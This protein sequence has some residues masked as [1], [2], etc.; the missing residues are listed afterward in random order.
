MIKYLEIVQKNLK[1][2]F[3]SLIIAFQLVAVNCHYYEEH[4]CYQQSMSEQTVL[5]FHISLREKLWYSISLGV[6]KKMI[7]VLSYRFREYLGHSCTVE[8]RPKTIVFRLLSNHV[9]GSLKFLKYISY[10]TILFLKMF[11]TAEKMR[12]IKKKFFVS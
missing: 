2:Q 7:K 1:E 8:G 3:L 12:K 11:K 5:R 6:K 9:F 10:E 4:N